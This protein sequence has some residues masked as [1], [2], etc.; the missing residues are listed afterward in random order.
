MFAPRKKTSDSV[1]QESRDIF[2]MMNCSEFVK[3]RKLEI[4]FELLDINEGDF[5]K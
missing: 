1:E 5:K 4:R 3:M 2:M